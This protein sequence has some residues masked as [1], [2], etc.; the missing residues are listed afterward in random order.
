MS[1]LQDETN[2]NEPAKSNRSKVIV[3]HNRRRGITMNP[4]AVISQLNR[5]TAADLVPSKNKNHRIAS[6]NQF[7]NSVFD[8]YARE[9]GEFFQ[10]QV[11]MFDEQFESIKREIYLN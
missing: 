3:R 6:I 10:D 8:N 4:E 9:Y 2:V 7:L 11:K 5:T 1:F